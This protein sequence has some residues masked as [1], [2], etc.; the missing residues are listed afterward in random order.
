MSTAELLAVIPLGLAIGLS[1]GALGGG[2]SILAVPVLVHLLGQGPVAAT[3][4]S[5][6]IVGITAALSLP[7]HHRAGRVRLGQG[8]TFGLLGVGGAVAGSAAS[9]AVE[10]DV[11]MT[12]FAVLMTVVAV[13]MLRRG[14]RPEPDLGPHEPI[15]TLNPVTCACPR[16]VKL[17][18]AASLVGLLTG[19]LGVGG[20]FV[21]V[22]AL[23]MVLGFPM[24]VAVG[25]S[26][27]VIAVNSATSLVARFQHGAGDLDWPLILG[28]A[29]A[30]VVGSLLGSRVA[31]RIPAH[32]LS[33]AFAVLV[34]GVA[35]LT[36][37]QALPGLLA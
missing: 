23:V 33:R 12:A 14:T 22:P 17:V 35:A 30:A 6:V 9:R 19:F 13:L 15:L 25:T 4:S 27:L 26:L 8:L 16:L 28:F 36:A 11:L 5:L 7:A 20:G 24:P 3:T 37:T 18:V 31:D 21:V 1:L 34:L 10:P 2:G 32:R 29:A